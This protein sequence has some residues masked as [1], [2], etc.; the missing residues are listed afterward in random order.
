MILFV[1]FFFWR[2]LFLS[3]RILI[4]V[5]R[6]KDKTGNL[7]A[8]RDNFV[9]KGGKYDLLDMEYE[10]DAVEVRSNCHS[11]GTLANFFFALGENYFRR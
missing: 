5:G 7:W 10:D 6:F 2:L 3:D 4:S 8:N 11:E 1:F 9:K